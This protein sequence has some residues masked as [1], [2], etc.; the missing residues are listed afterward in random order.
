MGMKDPVPTF[1]ALASERKNRFPGLA[2]LHVT[3][4]RFEVRVDESEVR[5]DT[6]NDFLRDLWAPKPYIS[7]GAATFKTGIEN[8]EKKGDV[9]AYGRHYL[10]NVSIHYISQFLTSSAD[11]FL[12][13]LTCIIVLR[14]TFP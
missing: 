10:A 3:E 12:P 13:S 2:Y 14:R 7:T 6:R 9:I 11:D 5:Q 1:A 4:A 8:A